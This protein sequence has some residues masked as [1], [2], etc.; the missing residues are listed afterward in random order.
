MANAAQRAEGE[1]SER[2][3]ALAAGGLRLLLVETALGVAERV[4]DGC[5]LVLPEV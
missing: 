1:T 5:R 2:D 4:A 3:G